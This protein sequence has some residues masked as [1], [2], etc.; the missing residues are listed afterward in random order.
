[1]IWGA[2]GLVRPWFKLIKSMLK[3]ILNN[4]RIGFGETF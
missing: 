2:W 1:M 3:L 4:I